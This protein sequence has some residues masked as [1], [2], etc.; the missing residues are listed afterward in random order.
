[1][2]FTRKLCKTSHIHDGVKKIDYI[3]IYILY[4]YIL[5]IGICIYNKNIYTI[6]IYLCIFTSSI[7]CSIKKIKPSY[8]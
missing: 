3:Y 7:K 6:Y 8:H 1:M 4:L 5:Y 2:L